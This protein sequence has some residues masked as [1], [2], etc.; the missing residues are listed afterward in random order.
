M[1]NIVIIGVTSGKIK[2]ENA[3]AD[4]AKGNLKNKGLARGAQGC[5]EIKRGLRSVRKG[6]SERKRGCAEC[7]RMFE[8]EK[9][10][11]RSAQGS[12]EIKTL[13]NSKF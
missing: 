2:K 13:F 3:C 9:A 5:F 4:Y 12:R 6:V 7:A 10:F 1:Q 11:A 8:N